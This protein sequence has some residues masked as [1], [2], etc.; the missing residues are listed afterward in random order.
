M[1]RVLVVL[2][3]VLTCAARLQGQD[4]GLG[5]DGPWTEY[6]I[7]SEERVNDGKFARG[8]LF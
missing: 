3:A 4:A 1:S 7:V 5:D 8:Q 2:F 6:D